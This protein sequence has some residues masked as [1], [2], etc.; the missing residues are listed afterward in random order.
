MVL[1]SRVL[2]RRLS[3][4]AGL[5]PASVRGVRGGLGRLTHSTTRLEV[6]PNAQKLLC[7]LTQTA[8]QPAR[9][10]CSRFAAPFAVLRNCRCRRATMARMPHACGGSSHRVHTVQI[11]K[12]I[13][14]ACHEPFKSKLH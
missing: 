12:L 4:A 14:S 13:T 6:L 3:W 10:C 5:R 8:S 2:H 7:P 9:L 1:C 11:E